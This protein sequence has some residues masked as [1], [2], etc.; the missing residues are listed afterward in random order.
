MTIPFDHIEAI[1]FDLDGTLVETDDMA[2]ARWERYLRPF[3]GAT[4]HV[5]ARWLLMKVETPGNMFITLLDW[6]HLDRPLMGFTDSLRR[7]RGVYPADEFRLIPG[8]AEM[9][10]NL[11]GQYQLGL[12]TTRSSYHIEQFLVRFPE[13]AEAFQVTV[14]L[15]DTRYLKPS[16]QPVLLAA[17]TLNIPVEKCVMV[18][19]TTVDV[20]SARRAGAWAV[21]VLCG[22]GER[23][24]LEKNGAHLILNSTAEMAQI[25]TD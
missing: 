3:F 25:V 11:S 24:E 21:G 5:K 23:S 4:A 12:I 18:G 16:P 10:L 13:I 17:K 8:V 9:I 2:V 1:F 15:Q 22:F 6:L 7:R 14:G 20:L 19:D